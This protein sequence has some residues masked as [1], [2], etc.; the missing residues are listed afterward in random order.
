M[1]KMS[2]MRLYNSNG[3]YAR[4]GT[5][6]VNSSEERLTLTVPEVARLFGSRW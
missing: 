4:G 6:M 2:R 1:M 3:S 5:G